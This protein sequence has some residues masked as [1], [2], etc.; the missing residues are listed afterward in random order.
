MPATLAKVSL[1]PKGCQATL[2]PFP[3]WNLQEEGDCTALQNIVDVFLDPED[4]LWVLDTGIVNSLD[5][6][7]RRC[8]PKV[9]AINVRTGKVC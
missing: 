6:P 7:I 5:E 8:P 2:N 3:N 4:I 9:V 1:K